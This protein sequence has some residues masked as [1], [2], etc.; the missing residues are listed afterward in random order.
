MNAVHP[1]H[2]FKPCFM[3]D[4][5]K[6]KCFLA[7]V[8]LTTLIPASA[9]FAQAPAPLKIFT[10][11]E[12]E[13]GTLTCKVYQLQGSSNLVDWVSIGA[14]VFGVGRDIN[15]V[16]STRNGSEVVFGS[17][18]LQEE[19]APAN[20]LAPWSLAGATLSLDD[21]PGQD[22]IQFTDASKGLDLGVAPD[23]FTYVFTRVDADTV[24]TDV[25]YGDGKK[26]V[27]TFTFTTQA[28]GT[29]IREEYRKERLK[30]RDLGVFSVVS[31][32]IPAVV[33]DPTTP[34]PPPV[35]PGTPNAPA[36]PP[37]S[38]A[39]LTYQFQSGENPD[40]LEFKTAS[41]GV[42]LGDDGDDDEPNLFSYS[43][44]TTGTNSAKVVLT[45]KPG[46]TNEYELTFA[47]A[48]RGSFIR[49]EFRDGRLKDTDNGAFSVLGNNPGNG[50]GGNTGGTGGNTGGNTG[51]TVDGV[52]AGPSLEGVRYT[53]ATG[54]TP[55]ILTFSSAAAGTETGDSDPSP[56]AYTYEKTGAA[57]ARLTVRFKADK[58]DEYDLTFT[59]ATKGSFVRREYDKSQLKDTDNGTFM[60][61]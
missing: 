48:G 50:N 12:V 22:L 47:T 2:E 31:N 7:S 37:T 25:D 53:F 32:T 36:E 51:G 15:Q 39:G 28:R 43:Y 18:R 57:T 11:V 26:D 10:A 5:N 6:A 8:I 44:T 3:R 46:R 29:W 17:Y 1:T 24:R 58:W 40:R 30:D 19:A 14:P 38:L 60:A 33:P 54:E 13:F 34:P 20:G 9:S 41:S 27:L 59:A 42:E 45:F 23:P 55:D 49:R 21:T 56:F 35:D 4:M 52:P 61:P 16:F